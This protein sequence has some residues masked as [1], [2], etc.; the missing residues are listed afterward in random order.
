MALEGRVRLTPKDLRD[1]AALDEVADLLKG[2][3]LTTP[4]GTAYAL[5]LLRERGLPDDMIYISKHQPEKLSAETA[6]WAAK[7]LREDGFLP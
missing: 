1:L 5:R 2:V 6:A 4:D 3:D 7:V